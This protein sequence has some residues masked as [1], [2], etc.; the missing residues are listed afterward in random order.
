[1]GE[2]HFAPV[3]MAFYGLALTMPA[4]AWYVMQTLMVRKLGKDSPL[5]RAIGRDLKGK[6]SPFLYLLGVA[7]AFVSP[8]LSGAFYV[9]VAL[10]WLAPDRRIERAVEAQFAP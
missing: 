8:W 3:P 1:M 7:S 5:A 4:V 6:V 2:N 10:M 9:A